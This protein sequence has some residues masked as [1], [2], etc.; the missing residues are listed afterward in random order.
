MSLESLWKEGRKREYFIKASRIATDV[1]LEKVEGDRSKFAAMFFE[2]L[3]SKE[4]TLL[5]KGGEELSA[6]Y[7]ITQYMLA[8]HKVSIEER[9][10]N[11]RALSKFLGR[12]RE[13]TVPDFKPKRTSLN[14]FPPRTGKGF[15][16][17]GMSPEA[18]EDPVA[19]AQYKA[20][21]Q[22]NKENNVFNSRQYMLSCAGMQRTCKR[23]KAYMAETFRVRENPPTFAAECIKIAR[24]SDEEAKEVMGEVGV[25]GGE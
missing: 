21:I 22:Q 10:V 2:S 17:A 18:I 23:I 11:T 7:K 12:I 6:M 9:R 14:V 3:L 24:L 4:A 19:R 15:R 16:L 5:E 25:K 8:N 1:T 13:E 20:A